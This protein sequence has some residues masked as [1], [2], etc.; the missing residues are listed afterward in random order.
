M[1]C[2]GGCHCGNMQV[3]LRLSKEPEQ[4][5]VRACTCSFCRAHNPRMISDPA[6]SIEISASDWD[7]VQLYRFGTRTCDILLCRRCGVF[8]AAVTD[9]KLPS[10]RAVVNVNCLNE[11]GRFPETPTMHNFDGEAVESRLAR[12]N[13]NWMP[14][15]IRPGNRSF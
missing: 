12:R 9:A 14:A 13:A 2:T 4:F 6:G 15:V 8:I 5:S 3:T 1:E 10:P 11:R 7:H